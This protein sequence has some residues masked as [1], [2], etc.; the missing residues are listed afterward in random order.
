MKLSAMPASVESS[1]ARGV[2]LRTPLGD[3]RAGQLDD[4]RT[5]SV[6]KRP[7]CHAIARRIGRAG[8]DRQQSWPAA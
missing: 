1:A 2:A 3:R 5:P 7:A 6:A 4:A 8:R